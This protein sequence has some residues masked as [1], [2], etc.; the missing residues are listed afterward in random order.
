VTVS[1]LATSALGVLVSPKVVALIPVGT[2]KVISEAGRP[3]PPPTGTV[4]ALTLPA[5]L[6][7]WKHSTR[8]IRSPDDR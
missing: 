1:L 8:R 6:D 2:P 5:V 3:P 4:K 7:N